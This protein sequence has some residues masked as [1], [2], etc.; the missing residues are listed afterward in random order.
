MHC[1]NGCDETKEMTSKKN[2]NGWTKLNEPLAK[3][4]NIVAGEWGKDYIK[5]FINGEIVGYYKGAVGSGKKLVVSNSVS[6]KG[7]GLKSGTDHTNQWPAKFE[8]DYVRVWGKEDT[9]GLLKDNYSFFE[10]S[11]QTIENRLLYSA[12]VKKKS[13]SI[14]K[15]CMSETATITMLPVFYNKYS[16]SIQGKNVAA[17][18]IDVI[19]RFNEKVAGFALNNVQYYIMDLSALPTGPYKVKIN[20]DGQLLEHDIPVINPEKIGEQRDAK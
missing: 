14:C 10:N 7:V 20:I 11:S 17:M 13:K 4:W 2:W 6:K 18:Q 3:D 5:F 8:V 12:D 15:N 16:V 9:T 1:L 19:D